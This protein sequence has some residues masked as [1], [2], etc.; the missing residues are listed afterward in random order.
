MKRKLRIHKRAAETLPVG[1]MLLQ[2]DG[3]NKEPR[4][5][6][7]T[8]VNKETN[9]AWGIWQQHADVKNW[10]RLNSKKAKKDKDSS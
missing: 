1:Y 5:Y 6:R 7:V 2:F 4:V 8:D 9:E 3:F 10:W